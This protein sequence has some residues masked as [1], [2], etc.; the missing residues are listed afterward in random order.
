[1]PGVPRNG[2]KFFRKPNRAITFNATAPKKE[3]FPFDES[4]RVYAG[5][6]KL[7]GDALTTPLRVMPQSGSFWMV[8]PATQGALFLMPPPRAGPPQIS[9]GFFLSLA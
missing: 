9:S 2:F 8:F 1:M 4:D 5:F 6:L 7:T 3:S